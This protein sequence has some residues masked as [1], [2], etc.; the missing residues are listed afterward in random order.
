MRNEKDPL[1][2]LWQQQSVSTPDMTKLKKRW[3]NLQWQHRLYYCM[4]VVGFLIAIANYAWAYERLKYFG[5]IW[6][7][8]M[9]I[10]LLVFILYIGWLR[11]HALS[12]MK[13][14]TEDYLVSLKAQFNNNIK[15]AR[16]TKTSTWMSFIAV[17]IFYFGGWFFNAISSDKLVK[18]IL[19]LSIA[20]GLLM[21]LT[22][23]WAHKREQKFNNEIANLNGMLK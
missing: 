2:N 19:P 4:D 7:G 5:Q 15:I 21:P 16:L 6:I 1:T 14:S 22:W 8:V 18:D 20:F 17:A 13:N 10:L 12:T 11:R 23:Y 9:L 3:K